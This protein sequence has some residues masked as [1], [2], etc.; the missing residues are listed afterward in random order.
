MGKIVNKTEL[1]EIFGVALQTIYTY[2]KEGM[3]CEKEGSKGV[4]AQYD[5]ALCIDWFANKRH[6]KIDYNRERA[7]LTKLQADK[8]QM[9]I[10]LANGMT[11]LVP[12]IKEKLEKSLG[13]LKSQL[14]ALP[15]ILTPSL[16]GLTDE[17]KIQEILTTKIKE[18]LID[19]AD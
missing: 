16:S 5:T 17:G 6:L 13:E 1:S 15:S 11:V 19:V 3:P 14:L 7:R 10:D 18:V 4:E 9:E 12:D 2:Q 8:V